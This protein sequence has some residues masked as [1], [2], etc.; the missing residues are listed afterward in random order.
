MKKKQSIVLVD[1]AWVIYIKN[2]KIFQWPTGEDDTLLGIK[3]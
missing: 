1:S 2:K 3:K